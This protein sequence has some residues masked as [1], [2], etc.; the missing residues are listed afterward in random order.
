MTNPTEAR[1]VAGQV[2]EETW[3]AQERAR[4]VTHKKLF[5][6]LCN[7]AFGAD[8]VVLVGHHVTY[9]HADG[10]GDEIA[11]ADTLLFS[12]VLMGAVFGVDASRHMI[13][14]AAMQ[15][16]ER[17]EYCALALDRIEGEA[18]CVVEG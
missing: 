12:P 6:R 3:L 5:S 14:M 11:S 13:A 1:L 17:E 16:G 7:I 4:N 10:S 8:C 15:P 18:P 2:A 9:Q